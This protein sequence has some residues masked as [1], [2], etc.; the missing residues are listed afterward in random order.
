MIAVP[1]LNSAVNRG[2]V[3]GMSAQ[4]QI[5]LLIL[6]F[7]AGFIAR[8]VGWLGPPQAG[9]M[10]RAVLNFGLPALFIA[11]ISRIPL[12]REFIALPV[13]AILIMAVTLGVSLLVAR[14]MQLPRMDQGVL[15]LSAISINNS[16]LFPFALAGWG[17]EG[18]S[19]L[20]LFDFGHALMQGSLVYALAAAYGGHGTS[21][22]A[23][24]RK[25]ASFPPLWALLAALA[26][27]L[28]GLVLPATL[29]TV[30]GTAGR[31]IL[32]LVVVALGILFDA[33]MLR[34][35]TVH[36]ALLLR[37]ALG[38]L[39]GLLCVKLF[40]LTGM[41]RSVV[42]LGSAAPIGFSAVV[43]ASRENL[44]RDLAASAA[45][46]SVLLGLFYVPV[47]LWLLQP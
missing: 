16:L 11:G 2:T 25:V 27:N 33:R 6:L 20:A 38:L 17:Q 29:T 28:S 14:R 22:W 36:V 40:G 12:R 5:G 43:L 23:I 9:W 42:L 19:Q 32:L 37:I 24:L 35:T 4:F 18:F 10:L 34:S 45:S 26:I 8:R 1:L 3:P 46:V 39:L 7:A 44:N 21:A 31:L 30:L 13:S 41:T 15:A 47:A